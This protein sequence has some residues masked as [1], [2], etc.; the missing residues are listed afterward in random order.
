MEK[1]YIILAHRNPIQVYRLI[2]QLDDHQSTFFLHIDKK[3]RV[4]AFTGL[5]EFG[6]KVKL[7]KREFSSWAS[8]GIVQ[9]TINA[10]EAIKTSG[11]P[12]QR[13]SGT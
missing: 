12:V 10:L 2:R 7:V 5:L 6:A 4:G 9:A 8:F 13:I 1:A 11:L 3:V